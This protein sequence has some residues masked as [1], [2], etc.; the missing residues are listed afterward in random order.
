[1]SKN[2]YFEWIDGESIG[3]VMLLES[4]EEIE[5]EYYFHF[6]NGDTC[7]EKYISPMT[8]NAHELN[9]K[10]IVEIDSPTNVWTFDEIE[11]KKF[12]DHET[13]VEYDV[14]SLHDML[15][16][17]S[18]KQS[19]LN[20]NTKKKIVPP[21]KNPLCILPLPT[22]DEYGNNF[23]EDT[24]TTIKQ[25][26]HEENLAIVSESNK[27]EKVTENPKKSFDPVKII[28]DSCKKHST[29]IDIS[30]TINLPA[31]SMYVIAESEF[32]NGGDKFIDYVVEDIDVTMIINTLKE[33]LKKSYSG[34]I[35]Q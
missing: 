7:A 31:K 25:K 8:T 1:M 26:T 22:I 9:G 28:V 11:N 24:V 14:P 17:H 21:K 20:G 2:R 29:D 6:N 3:E 30:I 16:S 15:Y 19:S 10:F 13:G 33:Q 18:G 27:M 32:E 12:T 34:L 4:I 5:G 23:N 35:E